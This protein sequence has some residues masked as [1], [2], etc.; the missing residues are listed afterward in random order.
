MP[1]AGFSE[2]AP[3]SIAGLP[4]DRG[5]LEDHAQGW[6]RLGNSPV[7][8][9]PCT[10]RARSPV[11]RRDRAAVPWDRVLDSERALDLGSVRAWADPVLRRLPQAKLP[12]RRVPVHGAA[13]A[14]STPKP[15]KAR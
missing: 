8:G 5:G 14:S 3:F 6:A 1:A 7:D 11:A 15:K 10:P 13:V 4:A 9:A 2:D 12:V